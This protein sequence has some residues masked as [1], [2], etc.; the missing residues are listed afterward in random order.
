VL[1]GLEHPAK[2][3]DEHPVMQ[4]AAQNPA[5]WLIVSRCLGS[6]HPLAPVR[7]TKLWAANL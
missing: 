6:A 3:Y 1:P 4:Q 2:G 7:R 5:Q